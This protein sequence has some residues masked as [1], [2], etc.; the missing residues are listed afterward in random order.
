[1][2]FTQFEFLFLF[3]PI[4][5][6][7]YFLIARFI[8]APV[9]RLSW[10][11]AASLVFYSYWDVHFVPIILVSIIVNYVMGLLIARQTNPKTRGWLFA[12]A[13]TA[14]LVALGFYKYTNFGIQILSATP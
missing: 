5:F 10:L 1:M 11:A 8:D 12:L 4:T 2:L 3:L 6:A 13:I 7:G 14:N 9:A